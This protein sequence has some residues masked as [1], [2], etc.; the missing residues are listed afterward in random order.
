MKVNRNIDFE[1]LERKY[2]ENHS[3]W[4]I[5]QW[6]FGSFKKRD[7]N[8]FIVNLENEYLKIRLPFIN[9]VINKVNDLW[10]DNLSELEKYFIEKTEYFFNGWKELDL[11]KSYIDKFKRFYKSNFV[12]NKKNSKFK[13]FDIESV[14]IIDVIS[15][16]T[17]LPSNLRRNFICPIPWHNEKTGSFRIY[18]N[19]NSFYCFWCHAWGNAVNFIS[20]IEDI[21]LKEAY[22]KLANIYS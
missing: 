21:D 13:N 14:S 6:L 10:W 19:S 2:F 22:I 1:D 12:N 17:R 8:K 5:E 16:Y 7:L 18:E 11:Y 20:A 4:R 9:D 15:S 3:T